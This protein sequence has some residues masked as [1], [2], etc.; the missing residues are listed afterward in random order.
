MSREHSKL[1][2]SGGCFSGRFAALMQYTIVASNAAARGDRTQLDE[3]EAYM[4]QLAQQAEAGDFDALAALQSMYN[5]RNAFELH[6]DQA[7]EAEN[8]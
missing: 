1:H 3:V 4:H 8:N 6:R 5:A 2:Y 7:A